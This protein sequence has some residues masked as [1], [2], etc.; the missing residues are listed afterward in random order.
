MRRRLISL[1]LL[2][3]LALGALT[4]CGETGGTG[5]GTEASPGGT[6]ATATTAP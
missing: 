5:T 2:A 3:A 4:A 6:M 1:S